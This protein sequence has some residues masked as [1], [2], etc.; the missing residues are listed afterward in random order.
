MG[1]AFAA[2]D[3]NMTLSEATGTDVETAQRSILV[4]DDDESIRRALSKTFEKAGYRCVSVADG[5]AALKQISDERFDLVITDMV[6]DG[7]SGTALLRRIARRKQPPIVIVITAYGCDM[8][9]KAAARYG[10]YAYLPKPVPRREL[11]QVAGKALENRRTKK[12]GKQ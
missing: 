10:A 8:Y 9:E 6:M 5:A 2:D 3:N 1:A 11:L 12:S 7:M 4:V